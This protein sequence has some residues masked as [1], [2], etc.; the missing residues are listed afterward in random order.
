MPRKLIAGRPRWN[1]PDDAPELTQAFFE[2]A[3]LRE[4]T[5]PNSPWSAAIAGCEAA[6]QLAS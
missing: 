5:E 2:R 1:D 4:G 3:E 6:C